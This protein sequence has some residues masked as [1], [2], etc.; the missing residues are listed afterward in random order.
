M[1]KAAPDGKKKK[2]HRRTAKEIER[3]HFCHCG[4]GYGS[5]GEDA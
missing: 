5:E 4:K 2:R 3:T 1:G